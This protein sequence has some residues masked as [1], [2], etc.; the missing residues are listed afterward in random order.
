VSHYAQRK[1][2]DCLNC[3]TEVQGRYC[4]VCGQENIEPKESFWHLTTHLVYDITHFDGKFFSSVKYLLTKPGF[5]S[6]EYIR[7][8][9]MSYLNPIKMYVFISAFFF[10]FFFSIFKGGDAIKVNDSGINISYRKLKAAIERKIIKYQ[11]DLKDPL[12]TATEKQAL[13]NKL[14]LLQSD[15]ARLAKD[16]TDLRGLNYYKL[17]SGPK[18]DFKTI[19]AYEA[20]QKKLSAKERDG[21]VM[22]VFTKRGIELE[23]KYGSDWQEIFR[24]IGEK[25]LHSFPQFLFVSLPLFALMLKLL[26]YRRKNFYYVDHII[27]TVHLFCAMFILM[28]FLFAINA[29]KNFHNLNWIGFLRVPLFLYIAWYQYKSLKNFYMQSRWKTV[30]KFILLVLLALC[31]ISLLFSAGLLIFVFTL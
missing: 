8:K 2:T 18:I 11:E 5:L 28:F 31:M 10:L 30:F 15:L 14:P 9:R 17:S 27:Y 29:L 4:H 23:R 19:E 13:Q 6:K 1:E 22:S 16:T 25:W 20:A 21:W 26:Y 3:G 7:G 12:T 24:R